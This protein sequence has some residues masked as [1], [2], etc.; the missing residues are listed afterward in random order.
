MSVF[1]AEKLKRF[2][3]IELKLENYVDFYE[4]LEWGWNEED[5]NWFELEIQKRLE[6]EDILKIQKYLKVEKI[7][8]QPSSC[9]DY[10]YSILW[11]T[12]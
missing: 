4:I 11:N 5:G 7:Y 8:F 9:R 10:T 2:L 1:S 3:E 12:K 6:L